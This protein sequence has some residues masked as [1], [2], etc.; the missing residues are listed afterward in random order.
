MITYDIIIVGGSLGGCAAALAA[1]AGGSSV[2]LL[3]SSGWLGG[4]YSAQGVTKPDESRYTSTVGSTAAY[5]AFQHNVRAFYRSNYRLSSQGQHQPTLNPGGAYPGFSTQPHVA[6]RILLQQLQA[7]PNVH[8]RLNT[9]VTAATVQGD[10]VQSLTTVDQNGSPAT[11][12]AQYFL[13]ATDLGELLPLAGVEHVIGA[14]GKDDTHEPDA[15]DEPHSEWIQPITVVV[16][17]ERRPAGE[18]HTI[19]KPQGYDQLKAQQQYTCVDGYISKVFQTPVDLWTYRRYIASSNFDDP[20]FAF[21]LSMLNM[22]AND[23]QSATL[24]TGDAA[25]DA[26]VIEAARQVSL[27][28]VYWLQTESPRDDGSGHGYPNIRVRPDEFGTPDGTAAQPYIRESRRIKAQYTIIQQDLDSNYNGGSRAKNYFDSCGIGFY[29]GLD[30]H[31]LRSVGME[32][33]FLGIKPFEIPLRALIPVRVKNVL[34]ACKNLGV[35]HI[36]NGAYRLHPIE[37]N[38][39]EA[40]GALALYAIDKGVAPASVPNEAAHLREF[41]Q[42]LLAR[43]VPLFWWSDLAFGDTA[44]AAAHLV[45]VAGIMSGESSAL[46][47]QPN[48]PFG[49]A[50]KGAVESKLGRSL[51]WPSQDMTRA[52]AAQWILTQV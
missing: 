19:A 44:Y 1:G 39:G 8:V 27:A 24:P 34:A 52:Q 7:L 16:S 47:F 45:G 3:E 30:I 9:R 14:E 36:T 32:Q 23:C 18:N 48:D 20:A 6:H 50:A 43:G 31:G 25:Q 37:W 33:Q 4:Q 13:D 11:Y 15:P 28:Y 40:A 29:G 17:L 5:R 10:T 42:R 51:N 2:C 26:A 35:T 49:D 21:D 22:G 38:V 12:L 46:D 41:Q